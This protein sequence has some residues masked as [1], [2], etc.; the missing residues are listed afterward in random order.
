MPITANA[1]PSNCCRFREASDSLAP[2]K[3]ARMHAEAHQRLVSPIAA[4]GYTL[5]ALAFL[6]TGGFD[7]RGQ[8]ERIAAAVGAIVI[9]QAAALGAMNLA[10]RALIFVPLMYAVGLL[11]IA[12]GL[13][14]IAA[15]DRLAPPWSGRSRAEVRA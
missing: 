7:K 6:L 15:P 13:Y 12:V 5:V 14:M 10:S 1:R 3:V 11:P 2:R 9:L 4:L 8:I